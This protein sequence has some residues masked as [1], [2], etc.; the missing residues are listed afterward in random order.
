[1]M[2]YNRSRLYDIFYIINRA[3]QIYRYSGEEK[4][5]NNQKD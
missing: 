2:R 4:I 5:G 1:M 3:L